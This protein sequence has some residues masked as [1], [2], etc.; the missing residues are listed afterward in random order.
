[1]KIISKIKNIIPTVVGKAST[2]SKAF[3]H[4]YG[5]G[6]M[7]AKHIVAL[8][9]GSIF[10]SS[11]A[12]LP[13]ELRS[14][15]LLKALNYK[16]SPD[17]SIYSKVRKEIGEEEIGMIAETI[18]QELYRYRFVSMVAIDSTYVQYYFAEDTDAA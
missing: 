12:E 11:D 13:E 17:S 18:I 2:V 8:G 9:I 15:G 6:K 5:G 14:R 3:G 4:W 16:N 10:R 1:M 7:H